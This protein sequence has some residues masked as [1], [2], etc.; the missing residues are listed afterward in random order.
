MKYLRNFRL[1]EAD[2]VKSLPDD[3]TLKSNTESTISNNLQAE[4]DL[5]KEFNALRS[6]MENIFKDPKIQDNSALAAA[7]LTGVYNSKKEDSQRNKWLKEFEA[8]LRMER[9]KNDLQNEINKDTDQIKLTNDDI[10]RLSSE[11]KDASLKR[12]PQIVSMLEKNRKKLKELKDNIN[13][14]KRLLSQDIIN[15]KKKHEDFKRD[16]KTE[17]ERIKNLLAKN[18]K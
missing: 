18:K 3:T 5:F 11:L 13:S 4:S 14:N 12:K 16:I 6:K 10:Y 8:V 15:W 9:R 17:E 1:F 2:D 7:L